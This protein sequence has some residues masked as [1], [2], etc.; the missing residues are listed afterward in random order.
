MKKIIE[1]EGLTD[2]V[3]CD[4]CGT[5]AYHIGEPADGRMQMYAEKRGYQ[6]DSLSRPFNAIKDFERF[7][8]IF[9]MD[10]QNFEVVTKQAPS[11]KHLEKVFSMTSFCRTMQADFVPDPYYRGDEG[12]EKVMDILEDACGGVLEMLKKNRKLS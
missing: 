2:Q 6:L 9:T 8:F 3:Q 7:D 10:P 11:K 4:S 5:S 12:F 1:K